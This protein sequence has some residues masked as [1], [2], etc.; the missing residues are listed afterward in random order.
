MYNLKEE[1]MSKYKYLI[2]LTIL[3]LPVSSGAKDRYI[4]KEGSRDS[5]QGLTPHKRLNSRKREKGEPFSTTQIYRDLA[6]FLRKDLKNLRRDMSF[7]NATSWLAGKQERRFKNLIELLKEENAEK[8]KKNKVAWDKFEIATNV[9]IEKGLVLPSHSDTRLCKDCLVPPKNFH[10]PL[11]QKVS[12]VDVTKLKK[13]TLNRLDVTKLKK[14]TLNRR[15]GEPFKANQIQVDLAEFLEKDY[16]ILREDK[17]FLSAASWLAG[18]QEGWF[19]SLIELLK[20]ENAE[21][22]KKNKVARDK[23]KKINEQANKK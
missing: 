6:D 1:T 4:I 16:E 19:K 17:F 15:K 12:P 22:L 23:F 8:F 2:M 7:L 5:H 13:N 3:F 10:L 20:E 9:S 11:Q 21:K 14:N 18:K